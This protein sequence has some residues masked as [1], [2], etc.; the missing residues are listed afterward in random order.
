M[1]Q[2]QTSATLEQQLMQALAG[3]PPEDTVKKQETVLADIVKTGLVPNPT[4]NA[5]AVAAPKPVSQPKLSPT[6][7]D[8]AE[9]K[10]VQWAAVAAIGVTPKQ[11]ANP[12]YWT[13]VAGLMTAGSIIH[14]RAEDLSWYMTLMVLSADKNYAAVQQLD[15]HE[16]EDNSDDKSAHGELFVSWKGLQRMHCVVRR[17]TGEVVRHGF[18]TRADGVMWMADYLREKGM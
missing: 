1:N 6:D 4:L 15:L 16:F 7:F 17:M 12:E 14:V 9:Q 13:H 5:P 8:L 2:P 18:R 10:M 11:A 3:K